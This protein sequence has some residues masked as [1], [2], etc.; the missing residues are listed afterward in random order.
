MT[1]ICQR[2]GIFTLIRWF[3]KVW[4]GLAEGWDAAEGQEGTAAPTE[5]VFNSSAVGKGLS[6]FQAKALSSA[7]G[8]G[9]RTN[10]RE[11]KSMRLKVPRLPGGVHRRD[12]ENV[13]LWGGAGC[14]LRFVACAWTR[15]PADHQLG[16]LVHH[17]CKYLSPPERILAEWVTTLNFSVIFSWLG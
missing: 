17:H 14:T 11:V 13:P 7:G 5:R 12:G 6:L 15:R 4:G 1:E 3:S 8:R 9:N 16:N 10:L 2:L